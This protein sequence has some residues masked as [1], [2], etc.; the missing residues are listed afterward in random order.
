MTLMTIYFFVDESGNSGPNIFDHNQPYLFYGTL[1]SRCNIDVLAEPFLTVLRR[2]LGVPRLHSNELGNGALARIGKDLKEIEKKFSLRFD[3]YRLQKS[4]LAIISFF[5]QVFDQGMNPAVPWSAYWT[6]LRYLLLVRLAMLFDEDILRKSWQARLTTND[7]K[8]EDLLR[9]V[10]SQ[11]LRRVDH[12]PDERS[13]EIVSDAL[14]WT[15]E[16][17]GKISYN[18]KE[19]SLTRDVMPNSIGFQQVLIGIA[20]RF[21]NSGHKTAKIVVD[22]Q[23]QFNTPQKKLTDWYGRMSGTNRPLGAGLPQLDLRGMPITQVT[24]SSGRNSAGLEL[25]DIYIWIFKRLFEGRDI[26]NELHP[27]V[28]R[29]LQVGRTDEISLRAI[30]E[31]WAPFFSKLSSMDL[32]AEQMAE[33]ERIK[34]ADER[35]RKRA[36]L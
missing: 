29:Q 13:K 14:H 18:A 36:F 28:D 34:E 5:D 9:S 23:S 32:T 11:L 31:R 4:D 12:L 33:G 26:P 27:L 24:I 1:T 15:M 7:K 19:K 22:Q 17:T 2:R 20:K 3:F 25:V 30:V 16:N 35:R 8:A 10:C 21:R 6:P